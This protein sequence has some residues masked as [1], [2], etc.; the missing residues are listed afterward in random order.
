MTVRDRVV[1]QQGELLYVRSYPERDRVLRENQ[2]LQ[3]DNNVRATDG[4]RP[5]ARFPEHEVERLAAANPSKYGDMVAPDAQVRSR[6]IQRFV[7]SSE[8]RPYRVGG[9]GRKS[10]YIRNNPLARK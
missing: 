3:K 1:N 10:V 5:F 2:Q 7:N 9:T 4:L 8:G 6:A